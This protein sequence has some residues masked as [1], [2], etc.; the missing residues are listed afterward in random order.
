MYAS[1]VAPISQTTNGFPR[2]YSVWDKTR[3]QEFLKSVRDSRSRT[4]QAACLRRA[5]IIMATYNRASSIAAAIDSVI[6]QSYPNWELIIVDDG[7][8]DETRD[9][10]A[11]LVARDCRI[12]FLSLQRSGVT[13]A[14]NAGLDTAEGDYTFFLDSDNSWNDRFLEI[15]VYFLENTSV[16]SVYSGLQASGDSP[17]E[18]YFRGVDFDWIECHRSNYIDLNS[19]GY[20]SELGDFR[21]DAMI[22]RL[23][24]WDLILR[25]TAENSCC[26]LPFLGVNYYDGAKLERITTSRYSDPDAFKG[27]V[28]YVRGKFDLHA[29][30]PK[31]KQDWT[32]FLP[33]PTADVQKEP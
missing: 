8:T 5:S 1:G 15:S 13:E 21:F 10:V 20:R 31:K 6:A 7:S 30:P 16:Q 17:G 24:D 27:L 9:V 26:Y 33:G 22:S 3:E 23:V 19:F 11:E 28:D 4:E 32:E 25:I 12:K 14:R 2:Q 29:L 18:A